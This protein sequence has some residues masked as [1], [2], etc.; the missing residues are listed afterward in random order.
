MPAISGVAG[1]PEF[2]PGKH[3]TVRMQSETVDITILDPKTYVTEANFVFV[4]DGPATSV[5]MGFPE[6]GY[7]DVSGNEKTSTFLSFATWVDG[8][9][10]QAKR[11]VLAN[12][13]NSDEFDAVWA[14]TVTFDAH[15]TRHVR[16]RCVANY[17]ESA[18]VQA[19]DHFVSYDFTGGNWKGQVDKSV[20]TIHLNRPGTYLVSFNADPTKPVFLRAGHDF[21]YTWTNWQA[22]ASVS[23]YF[24]STLRD[25]LEQPDEITEDAGGSI[26]VKIDFP[27]QPLNEG[28]VD[29]LPPAILHGGELMVSLQSWLT[30]ATDQN[31]LKDAGFGN[32]ILVTSG[33]TK[34]EFTAADAGT[35]VVQS[36]EGPAWYVP[37]ARLTTLFGAKFNPDLP[38][39]RIEFLPAK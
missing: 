37:A 34:T 19:P 9:P 28:L 7:G 5:R 26:P 10:I 1:R 12:D 14:K 22:E 23:F 25:F 36:P 6:R 35:R 29:Y 31:V 3:A 20:L 39:H 15:G 33:S 16:V 21:I 11:E 2:L 27:G 38:H 30:W 4:N 13:P 17:G 24:C 32:G 18:G 8:Q